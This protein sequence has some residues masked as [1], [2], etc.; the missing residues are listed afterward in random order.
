M[1]PMTKPIY[2]DEEWAVAVAALLHTVVQRTMDSLVV[3][4]KVEA[5]V[6]EIIYKEL[7]EEVHD[8][9]QWEKLR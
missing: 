8:R 7:L 6:T 2:R 1:R 3:I 4:N 9:V 5:N